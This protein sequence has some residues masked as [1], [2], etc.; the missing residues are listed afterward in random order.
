MSTVLLL[1]IFIISTLEHRCK[2]DNV[3]STITPD[4]RAWEEV[5]NDEL[6]GNDWGIESFTWYVYIIQFNP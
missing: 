4:G 5:H 3:S 2:V 1:K 6:A